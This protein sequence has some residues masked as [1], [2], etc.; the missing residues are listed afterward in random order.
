[1]LKTPETAIL[2]PY[3]ARNRGN[4]GIREEDELAVIGY[5]EVCSDTL[6]SGWAWDSDEPG[7]RLD[8]A[9]LLD[10]KPLAQ[11][12]A[13]QHREDLKAAGIG[14]GGYGFSYIPAALID[15]RSVTALVVGTGVELP[16][17]SPA[18][19][20]APLMARLGPIAPEPLRQRVAGTPDEQWFDRSGAL[21]VGEWI[22]LLGCLNRRIGE[23]GTVIDWGCGCGRALRHLAVRLTAQQRL[24]GIDVDAEAIA[25]M[26]ANYPQVPVFALA[27][28]PPAPIADDTADLIVSQ[29]IFTHLPED[30][31]DLWLAE[32]ARILKP[33]GLLIT[34]VHGATVL[35]HEANKPL[36]T[37]KFLNAMENYGFYYFAGRS[38]AEAALPEY[39]GSAF[40]TIDYIARC[41]TR[42]FKIRAWVPGL[43]LSYQDSLVLEKRS[44]AA[45]QASEDR[46]VLRKAP[47]RLPA[48]QG[49][50]ALNSSTD[51]AEVIRKLDE[52]Q[53]EF[54]EFR[55]RV[56]KALGV[57]WEE[58]QALRRRKR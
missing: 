46:E 8:V 1:M 56:E 47:P 44:A 10:G 4:L 49:T 20:G 2:P 11:V 32:L 50:K 18:E 14:D 28:T 43:A 38:E 54:T 17:L 45:D 58:I 55:Q 21:T 6:V 53:Q 48:D 36:V 16:H 30:I 12:T 23:F 37:P 29:S 3:P 26:K 34:T 57:G 9:I 27:E 33:G 13:R 7:R 25:W 52:I 51:G 22:A 15:T 35:E 19:P 5:I 40:H 31:A 24:I 41:W 39:Y 42:F